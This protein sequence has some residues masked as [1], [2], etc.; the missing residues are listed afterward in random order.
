M[1]VETARQLNRSVIW[2]EN[3]CCTHSFPLVYLVLVCTYLRIRPSLVSQTSLSL[4]SSIW[5]PIYDSLWDSEIYCRVLITHDVSMPPSSFDHSCY[6]LSS[7]SSSGA[8]CFLLL[9]LAFL[10]MR[11]MNNFTALSGSVYISA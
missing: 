1:I 2:C 10:E 7:S 11:L 3:K 5:V 4:I 8:F 6:R 9:P